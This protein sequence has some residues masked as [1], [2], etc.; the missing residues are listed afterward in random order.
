M[1]VRAVEALLVE[2]VAG[3][4]LPKAGEE[5]RPAEEAGLLR[6]EL[7]RAARK[8]LTMVALCWVA[9]LVLLATHEDRS[10][11]LVFEE[12]ETVFTLGILLVASYSGYRLGQWEKLRAVNR[13]VEE[14]EE[15]GE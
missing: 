12:L 5:G 3:I 6:E 1:R 7:G 15:R 9:I 10:R 14:L 11:F 13:V 4:V 8:A 2:E